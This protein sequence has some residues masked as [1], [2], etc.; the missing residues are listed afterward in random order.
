MFFLAV[1]R[2]DYWFGDIMFA[3]V[4]P[5]KAGVQVR[6]LCV[7]WIP[8]SALPSLAFTGMTASSNILSPDQ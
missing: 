8:G 1:G 7:D 3:F 4:T 6:N 2:A 5:A